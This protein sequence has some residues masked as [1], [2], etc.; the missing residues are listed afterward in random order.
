MKLQLII[1]SGE[2]DP[3]PEGGSV[4]IEI[5]DTSLADAPAVTLK[6][7]SV[8]VPKARRTMSL[9]VAIELRSVPDGTT[10]YAHLDA[11]GDGRVSRGDYVTVES[12]PL[13][14]EPEQ[15]L[16]LRMRRVK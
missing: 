5:R 4:N 6:R 14:R 10:V 7:V 1:Q 15:H 9:P 2:G 8:S 16:T 12:Y 3:L 13:T 11:D